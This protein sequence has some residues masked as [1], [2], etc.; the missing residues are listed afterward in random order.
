MPDFWYAHPGG[1][2]IGPVPVE[3][4]RQVY[5]QGVLKDSDFVW[6]EGWDAWR[7]PR[8]VPELQTTSLEPLEALDVEEL[9]RGLAL[10]PGETRADAGALAPSAGTLPYNHLGAGPILASEAAIAAL[11]RS[12]PWMLLFTVF[13][14]LAAGLAGVSGAITI[15]VGLVDGGGDTPVVL[16]IG[17]LVTVVA[18]VYAVPAVFLAGTFTAIGA[19]RVKRRPEDLERA[20]VRQARFWRALGFSLIV[21]LLAYLLAAVIAITVG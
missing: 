8:Y 14:L 4:L 6:A 5:A 15:I 3:G 18:L 17:L 10:R 9:P 11:H 20:L 2:Q 12:R 13:G 1:T 7:H 21:T 16:L 19:L